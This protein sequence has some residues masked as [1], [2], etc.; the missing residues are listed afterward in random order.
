MK[1]LARSQENGIDLLRL[2]R[3]LLQ[4][5]GYSETYSDSFLGVQLIKK[6]GFRTR[7]H[8]L[9][10]NP[11]SEDYAYLRK[12][13]SPHL[14]ES[15]SFNLHYGKNVKLFETGKVYFRKG[16]LPAEKS[17]LSFFSTDDAGSQGFYI[18]KGEI[19]W[20]LSGLGVLDA[21]FAS[22]GSSYPDG[23]LWHPK[24][25]AEIHLAGSR[26]GTVGQ[27]SPLIL[28]NFN[29]KKAVFAVDLNYARLMKAVAIDDLY[30]QPISQ[31]PAVFRDIAL[32]VSQGTRVV[33]VLNVINRVGG[34]LVKDVD[35][36]DMY[37]GSEL[38]RGKKNL[39]FHII[40]QAGD[41]TLTSQEVERLHGK[42][43][44]A[45]ED[46]MGWEVRK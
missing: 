22:F 43:I 40:Y 28:Q 35:L 33:D 46:E 13:L 36:F 44:K 34:I 3:N 9:L 10:E 8:I 23:G 31:H 24:I 15:I 27:I 4:S 17:M 41:R 30:Y 42:I 7:D 32:F 18:I 21:S 37:E 38:P 6:T 45:L 39:A 5:L 26:L 25:S 12:N 19:E 2:I 20:L 1:L 16:S 11:V 14:L 29:I